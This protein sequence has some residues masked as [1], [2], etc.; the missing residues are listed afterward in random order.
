MRLGKYLSGLTKPE[1]E[2]IKDYC[3]FTDDEIQIFDMLS[4][5]KS[6][7]EISFVVLMT[8]RTISR[9]IQDISAKIERRNTYCKK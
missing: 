4:K 2:E 7:T 6:I 9:R 8:E 3:N 1:L 5:K